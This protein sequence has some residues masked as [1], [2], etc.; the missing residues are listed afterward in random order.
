MSGSSAAPGGLSVKEFEL[1]AIEIGNW[2]WGTAQG[3]FNE[4]Q[5][6]AQIITD[7]GVGMIPVVGDVTA[8]RD[9]FA[10]GSGL[11][12]NPEKRTHTMEW[13]LLVIFIFAL[14]PV[15]GGVIK[16]VG[17]IALRVAGDVA[18]DSKAV[19]EIAHEV[20]S[21]LNRIGHKNA[22]AWIKSLDILKYEKQILEKFRDFC[23]M[24]IIAI[25]RYG[26]RFGSILPQSL[27]S[28]MEQFS[29]GF[30]QIKELGDKMIP[31]ALKELYEKLENLK[32]VIRAGGL[33]PPNLAKTLEVQTGRKTVSYAEEARLIESGAAKKLVHAGKYPQ[34]GANVSDTERIGKI[35]KAEAGFPNLKVN[36]VTDVPTRIRY[37]PMIAASSGPIKNEILQGETLFRAFGP[38]GMT[39]GVKVLDS[40]PI[41]AFWGRGIPPKS[42]DEW[43]K[44]YAVIDEWNRNG[45]LSLVHIPPGTKIPAC[46]S[47]VSEQFS[48]KIG[49]QFLEGGG[50]QAVV[51]AFFEQQITDMTARLIKRGGGKE[52]ITLADGQSIIVEVRNSGWKGIN[53]KIGYG[54]TVI[55]GA[56]MTERLGV[57]ELQLKI[58]DES[59]KQAAAAGAAKQQNASEGAKAH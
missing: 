25:N 9:L 17:R 53:G 37:Y 33:P 51:T 44:K 48:K 41:G 43:R 12:T 50:Q 4:K 27:V 28:R 52:S 38:E 22:E 7:A 42:A 47:T 19:A 14:I 34:N 3:A 49:G 26:L 10:V 2:I 36:V 57:T 45:W 58:R 40:K 8:F 13:V 24:V 56:S 16:G 15:L 32:Q 6:L 1:Y 5:T 21:F 11:A 46:T 18:K 59:G 31:Q 20:I 23:D 35:Y 55:P 39:H 54:E 30:K 29:N